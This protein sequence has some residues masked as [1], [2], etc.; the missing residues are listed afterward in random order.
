LPIDFR[1][2]PEGSETE[3]R[4]EPLDVLVVA[5]AAC[6]LCTDAQEALA[7][8]AREHPLQVRMVEAASPEGR[9][10]VA[11]HRPTMFPLVLVD[12]EP[13]STGR[14]PRGKLRRLLEARAA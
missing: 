1:V 13:F 9:A 5:A 4:M 6:H 2:D 14:L 12:G 10:A 8:F 3:V 7:D 11:A